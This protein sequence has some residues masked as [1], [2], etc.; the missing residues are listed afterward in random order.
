MP[1][2]NRVTPFGEIVAYP[3]RGLFM[4]NRGILVDA[5]GNL[6]RRRWSSPAWI[7]CALEFKGRRLPL[8]EPGHNTQL[9]FLDEATALAAGHRPCGECRRADFDRFKAL[10]LEA[11][12]ARVAGPL[13]RIGQ[14]DRAIHVER[15]HARQRTQ[16]TYRDS[17]DALANGV[18]VTLDDAR[19][20][21]LV[22]DGVLWRWTRVATRSR[23]AGPAT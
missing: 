21:Y 23:S 11:N 16:L 19:A 2:Q 7:T 18:F 14:I 1:R 4:G 5:H 22:W 17:L 9:F 8:M 6:T 3:E 12:A 13:P 15:V 20:A 10:W